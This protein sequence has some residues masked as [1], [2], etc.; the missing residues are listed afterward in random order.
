MPGRKYSALNRRVTVNLPVNTG[1]QRRQSSQHCAPR[2]TPT[3]P[4]TT[5]RPLAH[6]TGSRPEALL[7]PLI[8]YSAASGD[9][10]PTSVGSRFSTHAWWYGSSSWRSL[11]RLFTVV[12]LHSLPALEAAGGGLLAGVLL[13]VLGLRLTQ[14]DLRRTGPLLHAEFLYWRGGDAAAGGAAGLP[15]V[16]AL[17]DAPTSPRPRAPTRSTR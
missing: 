14:F 2:L 15:D 1:S 8:G 10:A 4:A 11:A 13:G 5:G 3:A 9:F 6:A 16:H 12:A 7:I 17:L